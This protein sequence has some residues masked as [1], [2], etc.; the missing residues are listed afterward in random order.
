MNGALSCSANNCVHYSNN[1]CTANKI[2]VSGLT[3]SIT[4]D[5]H[6]ATFQEKNL[7][8]TLNSLTNMNVSG[9][10]KQFFTSSG[11]EMYPQIECTAKACK[12]NNQGECFAQSIDIIGSDATI[13]TATYCNTFSK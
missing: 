12:Y 6:C 10:I 8:N 13:P 5:T 3:A 1:M 2:H 7:Q 11:I 9:E 4:P